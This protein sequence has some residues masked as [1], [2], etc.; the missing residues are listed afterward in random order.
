VCPLLGRYG[1]WNER[2]ATGRGFITALEHLV[3]AGVRKAHRSDVGSS[4][5]L[6]AAIA[7]LA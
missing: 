7:F 6:A 3:R 5:D 4:D 1:W 2:L